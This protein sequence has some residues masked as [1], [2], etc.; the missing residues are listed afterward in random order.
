MDVNRGFVTGGF[1]ELE[2]QIGTAATLGY[3]FVEIGMWGVGDREVL[4]ADS[5]AIR[6]RLAETGLDCLVHLPF[7]GI[8]VGAPREHV[9]EGALRELEASLDLA[10]DLGARKAVVHPE[11]SADDPDEQRRL[12]AESISRLDEYAADRDI[13]LCAENMTTSYV[14]LDDIDHLLADTD[15]MLI[16]DTGHAR[17]AGY[18]AADLGEFLAEHGDRVSHFHLNDT[19]GPSDDHLSF[20]AGTIDFHTIFESLQRTDWSGTL[21]VESQTC[22]ADYLELSLR[23]LDGVLDSV[24]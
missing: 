11:S 6:D 1:V 17:I 18:E 9:R 13:V 23:R 16:I 3:D 10:A 21:S 14:T 12:V 5:G 15:T 24:R 20:G 7:G 22:D 8:D 4:A 19:T 2:E